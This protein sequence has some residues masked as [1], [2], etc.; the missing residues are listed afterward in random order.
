MADT[1]TPK[2]YVNVDSLAAARGTAWR[3][4]GELGGTLPDSELRTT[5]VG[6]FNKVA[7]VLDRLM[8]HANTLGVGELDVDDLPG[9][10]EL[11][12]DG[13]PGGGPSWPAPV[14]VT[15]EAAGAGEGTGDAPVSVS[16]GEMSKADLV[17][18]AEALGIDVPA[19]A[20]KADLVDLIEGHEG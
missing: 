9:L 14:K 10:E 16:L 1:D 5:L 18:K 13:E 2:I 12:D 20:T 8:G 4:A 19:K 3:A 15:F 6:V 7:E 11:L 17:S